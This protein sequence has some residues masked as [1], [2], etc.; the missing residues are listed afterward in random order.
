MLRDVV[1]DG[2]A[3]PIFPAGHRQALARE[4]SGAGAPALR[5]TASRCDK[6]QSSRQL[7]STTRSGPVMNLSFAVRK[8]PSLSFRTN[9]RQ[10]P[11]PD[12]ALSGHSL[13]V[14]W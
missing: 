6:A 12:E 10:V 9:W 14:Y 11:R 4:I 1:T 7:R 8:L 3:G 2:G 13:T 5:G